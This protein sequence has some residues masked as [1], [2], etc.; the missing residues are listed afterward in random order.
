[1]FQS[2][3]LMSGSIFAPWF[4]DGDTVNV[5]L[6]VA[7]KVGC[8]SK[9]SAEIVS[10]M[11]LKSNAELLTA[12]KNLVRIFNKVFCYISLFVASF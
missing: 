4:Y 8:N 12:I 11:K 1:M 9:D 2:A 6:T 5:S 7:N 3:I 10:C